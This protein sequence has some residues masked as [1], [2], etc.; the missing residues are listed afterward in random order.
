MT[1]P[2]H[3][4]TLIRGSHTRHEDDLQKRY[5]PGDVIALTP[6]Q[7]RKMGSRVRMLTP[8]E[9]YE[10]LLAQLGVE[11]PD[12]PKGDVEDIDEK[13]TRFL[14]ENSAEKVLAVV[15]DPETEEEY[16]EALDKAEISGKGR[17]GVLRA[18][19]SRLGKTADE[20]DESE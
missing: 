13:A 8:P 18:L 16:L 9:G 10:D 17:Q 1:Q 19:L 20:D 14:D 7:A 6:T 5:M 2:T 4:Y 12:L 3:D 15:D 11:I